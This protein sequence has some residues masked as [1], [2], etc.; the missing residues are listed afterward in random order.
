MNV[1]NKKPIFVVGRPHSGNTMVSSILGKSDNLFSFID[2]D[3]FF[4]KL[5]KYR[6]LKSD[7]KREIRKDIIKSTQPHIEESI[8]E[9]IEKRMNH[10]INDK[11]DIVDYYLTLK[12]LISQRKGF[13]RWAQKATSYIFAIEEII[14]ILPDSKFIFMVRNPFDIA[15][16]LKRRG[17]KNTW[18][19][20]VWGWNKGVRKGLK[21][22][23]SNPDKFLLVKYED[24]IL[25]PK[26]SIKKVCN[27]LGISFE[28]S[29]LDIN[30]VNRSEEPHVM[31][32]SYSG[33]SKSR[34]LYFSDVLNYDEIRSINLL[35]DDTIFDDLYPH[36]NIKDKGNMHSLIFELVNIIYTSTIYTIRDN[37]TL[38]LDD[39]HRYTHRML[40]RLK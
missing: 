35:V 7:S 12:N 3:V 13:N 36:I 4:E 29:L 23:S 1:R 24:V 16:S 32:S 28:N 5:P 33:I 22:R 19:R 10:D 14:D 27:F 38:L 30:H 21:L 39:P 15:A 37:I 31:E 18:V 20:M 26:C 25:N 34:M 17:G 6:Y 40:S 9:S 2:E 8:L 11:D